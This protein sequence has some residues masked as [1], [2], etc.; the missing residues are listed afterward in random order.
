MERSVATQPDDDQEP[1]ELTEEF[2]PDA[3]PDES[4]ERGEDDEPDPNL[5]D[6]GGDETVVA[7]EGEEP[8]AEPENSTVRQMRQA[9]REKDKRIKE[10]EQ[11]SAPKPVEVGP[12]P[13]LWD[14]DIAGDEEVYDKRL[15]DW[16]RTKDAAAKQTE[17]Q[18]EQS[19]RANE[20]W[21]QDLSTFEQKKAAL[22][23]EDR[24]DMIDTATSAL[25]MV[26]QA[27]VVKAA[28]DPALFLYALGKSEAKRAEL[29]KIQDPIKL[30]AAVARMEG[31]V[32]VMTRKAPAPDRP[33][34]G[35]GKLP[36]G[37]DKELEKLERQAD[38]S[39][40]FTKLIAYK[41]E[42]GLLR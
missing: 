10:L 1:L 11:S 19:R 24:D 32:K 13:G 17:A 26:Q 36:Q 3:E 21:Q 7:F 12:K 42:K 5:N 30:A 41:R 37:G 31:A 18:Q 9:L 2:D 38:S 35:S 15:L 29:A 34:N 23:L 33:L 22:V 16:Q 39:G 25:D 20:A 14:D 8:E 27:V 4:D 6:E 40:D 28:A